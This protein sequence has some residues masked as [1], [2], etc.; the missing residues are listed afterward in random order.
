MYNKF[1]KMCDN[2]QRRLDAC[3]PSAE[4]QK[5][6]KYEQDRKIIEDKIKLGFDVENDIKYFESVYAVKYTAKE[7]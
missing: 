5:Q 6:L 2:V 4:R 3:A 1:E 7:K